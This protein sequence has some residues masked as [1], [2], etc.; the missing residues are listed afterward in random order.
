MLCHSIKFGNSGSSLG[1]GLGLRPTSTLTAVVG[2]TSAAAPALALIGG[3]YLLV[4]V[5]GGFS[6]SAIALGLGSLRESVVLV[7]VVV[8]IVIV[9]VVLFLLCAVAA[10]T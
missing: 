5:G 2:F 7:V 3:I 8:A 1:A 9:V 4:V 6:A 10:T